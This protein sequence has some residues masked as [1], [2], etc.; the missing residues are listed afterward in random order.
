MCKAAVSK[1]NAF[2]LIYKISRSALS[3]HSYC[4][5]LYANCLCSCHH[6]SSG[7]Y[8]FQCKK[9][10]FIL[11]WAMTLL[12]FINIITIE[13]S[14]YVIPVSLSWPKENKFESHSRARATF[15]SLI[16][17]LSASGMDTEP[18]S[19]VQISCLATVTKLILLA[20]VLVNR[21]RSLQRGRKVYESRN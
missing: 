21:L 3:S 6:Y 2:V 7:F 14:W 9:F 20:L 19:S 5:W 4:S 17:P 15:Y 13:L 11:T 12:F 18:F 10:R 1:A 8:K 16:F